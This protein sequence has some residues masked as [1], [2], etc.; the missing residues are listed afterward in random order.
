MKK[1]IYRTLLQWPFCY[2]CYQHF[3]SMQTQS[4][5]A[6]TSIPMEHTMAMLGTR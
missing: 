3:L 5:V 4:V 2:H 1:R 6:S